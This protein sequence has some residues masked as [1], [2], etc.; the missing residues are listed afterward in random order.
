[1]PTLYYKVTPATT[2]ASPRRPPSGNRTA[3]TA[4]LSSSARPGRPCRNGCSRMTRLPPRTG[5]RRNSRSL[6]GRW[7]YPQPNAPAGIAACLRPLACRADRRAPRGVLAR[8]TARLRGVPA[9]RLGPAQPG[10]GGRPRR[11]RRDARPTGGA[12]G[13]GRPRPGE[14]APVVLHL[15]GGGYVMGS[16]ELAAPLAGR[17][18]EA[19]G[20]WSLVPDYRLAPEHPFPAA[21]D[22]PWLNRVAL[23]QLAAR[24]LHDADPG[25]ALVSPLRGTCPACRRRSSR[26]PS[27]KRSSPARRGWPNGRRRRPG[28]VQRGRR[29][30]PLVHPVRLPA[31]SGPRAGGVGRLRGRSARGL[32]PGHK[33]C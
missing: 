20:G 17:L 13:A 28:H 12:G 4:G 1:M 32:R 11:L 23:I 10:C 6:N 7:F 5:L 19:A 2:A 22:D 14:N 8:R 18:A 25:Q 3:T 15:H 30:R 24:S 26:Q 29:Q 31:R 21:L 9:A 27:T 16:A 33:H